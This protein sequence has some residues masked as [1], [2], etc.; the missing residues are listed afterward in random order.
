MKLLSNSTAKMAASLF[1]ALTFL[2]LI[3]FS[4][5][6]EEQVQSTEIKFE[7]IDK[8]N[9][10][11]EG[12]IKYCAFEE[13]FNNF[14]NFANEL[15]IKN[16][17]NGEE[18]LG[19][20]FYHNSILGSFFSRND[21]PEKDKVNG[22]SFFIKD[23]MDI[24]HHS[25]YSRKNNSFENVP[26]LNLKTNVIGT[27]KMNFVKDF[28][29]KEIPTQNY[30]VAFNFTKNFNLNRTDDEF[31]LKIGVSNDLFASLEVDD[32]KCPYPC[33]DTKGCECD[34]YASSEQKYCNPCGPCE[35]TTMSENG[36]V[37]NTYSKEFLKTYLNLDDYT[38]FRENF[39]KNV[40]IGRKYIRY[41][42]ALGYYLSSL[43][44]YDSK[45]LINTASHLPIVHKIVKIISSNNS[46][47]LNEIVISEMEKE[48]FVNLLEEYKKLSK[49]N[50]FQKIISDIEK[51]MNHFSG[52]TKQE[53][54]VYL[55]TGQD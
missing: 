33:T 11:A 7:L 54:L 16:V 2:L 29:S 17:K 47:D 3:V 19:I 28:L 5:K 27:K 24:I 18:I 34:V 44:N 25:F 10:K 51:D 42:E 13:E 49:N 12:R 20:V 31:L 36:M 1:I 32:G 40:T 45:L 9:L 21:F 22:I 43:K 35:L 37:S 6:Q 39:L 15:C 14:K 30:F 26:E 53:L 46:K 23:E 8:F 50:D 41:Y 4:C 48:K 52:K 55:N 38:K